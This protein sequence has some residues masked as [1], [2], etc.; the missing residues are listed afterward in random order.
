[1]LGD[2]EATFFWI[3]KGVNSPD[4]MY[5]LASSSIFSLSW[6]VLVSYCST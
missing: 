6:L 5:L 1:M 2:K 4:L 3:I